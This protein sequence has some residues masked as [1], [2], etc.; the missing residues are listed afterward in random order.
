MSD[1][2]KERRAARRNKSKNIK[3]Q[4]DI[5]IEM[6]DNFQ[7]EESDDGVAIVETV[8]TNERRARALMMVD[9][10]YQDMAVQYSKENVSQQLG[11]YRQAMDFLAHITLPNKDT[12][13]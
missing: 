11:N 13:N 12:S 7:E 5:Y 3:S 1:S 8:N 6:G 4:D 10:D 9:Y 2:I